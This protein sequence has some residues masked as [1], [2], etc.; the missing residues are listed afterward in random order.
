[1]WKGRLARAAVLAGPSLLV[2]FPSAGLLFNRKTSLETPRG[3]L[4]SSK[5]LQASSYKIVGI[6][7][8]SSRSPFVPAH[9]RGSAAFPSFSATPLGFLSV[10]RGNLTRCPFQC[11]WL[12]TG[13]MKWF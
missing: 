4:R 8:H 10:K 6:S 1:M 11:G 3:D 2:P 5:Y 12:I 9:G 7:Y 13:P